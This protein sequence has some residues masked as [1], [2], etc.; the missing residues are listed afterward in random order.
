[1]NDNINEKCYTCL[2]HINT[3]NGIR[4]DICGD[5]NLCDE[6]IENKEV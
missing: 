4:K 2:L 6:Y 3:C 1:M 5:I